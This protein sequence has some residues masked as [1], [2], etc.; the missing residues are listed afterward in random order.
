TGM[1]AGICTGTVKVMYAGQSGN[2]ELDIPVTLFVATTALLNIGLPQGFGI[3]QT[4]I[5]GANISRQ[6]AMTS[7]DGT[8]VI[9]YNA[10]FS[11]DAPCQWLFAAPLTGSTPTPLQVSIQPGCIA[12]PGNYPGHITITSANLPQPVNLPITL[13]VTSNVQVAVTPQALNFS[14]SQG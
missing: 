5:G 10:N 7:T 9:T 2:T 14:Q 1:T 13:M 12:A 6:L 8:T 3:E 4:T 11:A